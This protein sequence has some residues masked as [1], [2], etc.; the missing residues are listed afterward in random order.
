MTAASGV[1]DE[2]ALAVLALL[3]RKWHPR[4]VMALLDDGPLG[5]NELH[6]SLDGISGKV[7]SQNVESLREHGLISRIVVNESP[8]RVEYDITDAG[9]ELE[10]VF[11]TLAGWGDHH[12]N[13]SKPKIVIADRDSR[14]TELYQQ[15]LDS[16]AI[17][18]GVHDERTLREALDHTIDVVVYDRQFAAE[19]PA[20]VDE[21]ARHANNACRT[22]LLT[23]DRPGLDLVDVRCDTI[24][25]K[26]V[27]KPTFLETVNTQL[28][29]VGQPPTERTYHALL[30][31]RTALEAAYTAAALEQSEQYHIL[32][33]RL[34]QLSSSSSDE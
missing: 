9:A 33:D 15:W 34:D 30:E 19:G 31:K 25:R 8:L 5:F 2:T 3:S 20:R 28:E 29:R 7:L 22:V 4:I 18:Y 13:A 6:D 21:L 14:L 32:C 23:A 26:P 24:V 16:E 1:R 17:V 12:L 10:P 27:S 11:E